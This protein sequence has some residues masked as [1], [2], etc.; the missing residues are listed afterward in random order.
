MGYQEWDYHV[1]FILFEIDDICR[2]F[3]M[4]EKVS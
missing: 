4:K 2:G 3:A 1:R